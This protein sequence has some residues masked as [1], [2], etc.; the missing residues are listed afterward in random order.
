MVFWAITFLATIF[1]QDFYYSFWES[2][3][4]AGGFL[5]FSFYIIF[6]LLA[7]LFIRNEDWRKI[8]NFCLIIGVLA[9]IIAVFQYFQIFSKY[10][11]PYE[12]RPPSTFGNSLFLAIY[13]LFLV[14]IAFSF[15]LKEKNLMRRLL[16]LSAILLFIFIILITNNRAS[17]LGLFFG[18]LYFFFFYPAVKQKKILYLKII[19]AVIF[20]IGAFGIYYINTQEKLPQ[21]IAN[22]RTL[23]AVVVR[24]SIGRL[25]E[26]SRFSAWQVAIEGIKEKP[27]LGWGPEN[28]AIAFDKYYDP[29]IPELVRTWWDRTHN[30]ALEIALTTGI[31]NLIVY[32]SFF[33]VLFWQLQKTK[34]RNSENA[35]ACHAVQTAFI[36]YFVTAF[37]SFDSFS[38]YIILFVLI[39]YSLYLISLPREIEIIGKKEEKIISIPLWK[40]GIQFALICILV[41]FIW[42]G[43]LRPL[44]INKEINWANFYLKNGQCDKAVETMDKVLLS[45]SIVDSYARLQYIDIISICIKETPKKKKELVEKAVSALKEEI[46]IRPGYTRGW[47]ALG[48]YLNILVENKDAF[49][50]E[51]VNE[52]EKESYLYFSKAYELGPHRQE[53]LIGW[54]E[55]LLLSERYQEA[56]E[57]ADRCI[58]L[59]EAD[60][61]CWWKKALV[62]IYLKEIDESDKNMAIAYE[63]GQSPESAESLSQLHKAYITTLELAQKEKNKELEKKCYERLAYTYRQLAQYVDPKNFQYRASAAHVYQILGRYQ[64]AREQALFTLMVSKDLEQNVREFLDLILSLDNNQFQHHLALA[65]LYNLL[66]Q[67]K[68]AFNEMNIAKNLASPKEMKEM[69]FFSL[70]I[71][72]FLKRLPS[73]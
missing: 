18:S 39:A 15:L 37:F 68:K 67:P 26:E 5:N 13:L 29:R 43:A 51:N 14:F 9:S 70:T 21:F 59:N 27:L 54:I 53:T 72:E 12:G 49:K 52:L 17:Y 28:F 62:N 47:M 58:A 50:I 41:I 11:I 71:N 45:H 73:Y 4:R 22:N 38:T 40:S 25:L 23:K 34:K 33:G 48:T 46:E 42:S 57:M 32:L 60:P 3:F 64:E 36:G 55:N 66:D 30:F 61:H 20:L 24:L 69:V 2:P 19:F 31:P 8:W 7:F 44:A 1:S 6:A 56:K 10:L 35:L 65:N 63:K 16:Y